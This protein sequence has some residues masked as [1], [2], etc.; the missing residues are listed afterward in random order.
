MI[1]IRVK[2]PTDVIFL[3]ACIVFYTDRMSTINVSGSMFLR[4]WN[5]LH[6]NGRIVEKL[7]KENTEE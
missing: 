3:N 6:I 4:K 5:L 7:T 2:I 1:F